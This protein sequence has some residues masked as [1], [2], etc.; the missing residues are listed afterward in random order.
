MPLRLR[1][2]LTV[3]VPV[4]TNQCRDVVIFCSPHFFENL[5]L[6]QGEYLRWGFR[7]DGPDLSLLCDKFVPLHRQ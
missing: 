3:H 1:S 7:S 5:R 6:R 4:D 2:G